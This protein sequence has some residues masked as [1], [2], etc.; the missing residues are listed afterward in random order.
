[1][2]QSLKPRQRA[3]ALRLYS[4]GYPT[5]A[6]AELLKVSRTTAVQWAR[7]GGY[8]PKTSDKALQAVIVAYFKLTKEDR[9]SLLEFLKEREVQ[10]G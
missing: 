3:E 9:Q 4:R 5:S 8:L 2:R 10:H 6:V 1:M 7:D